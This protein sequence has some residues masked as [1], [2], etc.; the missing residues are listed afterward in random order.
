MHKASLTVF[1]STSSIATAILLN[2]KIINIKSKY[3]GKFYNLR[4]DQEKKEINLKQFN[5]DNYSSKEL[6]KFLRKIK[7]SKSSY[8]KYINLKMIHKTND[9]W[10]N[11]VK[12]VLNKEFFDKKI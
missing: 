1:F 4:A 2:K 10:Y 7:V 8:S 3:L 11:Q 5:I 12:F 6:T 9:H